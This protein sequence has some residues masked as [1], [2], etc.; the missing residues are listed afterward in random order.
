MT[1]STKKSEIQYT[2]P[3]PTA[4]VAPAYKIKPITIKNGKQ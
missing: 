3:T 2:E 1:S 4:K